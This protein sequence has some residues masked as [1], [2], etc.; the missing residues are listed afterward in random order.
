MKLKAVGLGYGLGQ[1][2][3]VAVILLIVMREAWHDRLLGPLG[4][5]FLLGEVSSCE[6]KCSPLRMAHR[7]SKSLALEFLLL[8]AKSSAGGAIRVHRII[9]ER[10]GGKGSHRGL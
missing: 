4:L 2:I 5:L 8:S 10:V 3:P 1:D 7:A 9:Q 6:I